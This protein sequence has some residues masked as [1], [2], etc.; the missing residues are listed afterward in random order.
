MVILENTRIHPALPSEGATDRPRPDYVMTEMQ[1]T[2]GWSLRPLGQIQY[3]LSS[4][5]IP[6]PFTTFWLVLGSPCNNFPQSHHHHGRKE[7]YD[8]TN[9]NSTVVT[10]IF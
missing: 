3:S 9:N 1:E 6:S 4:D 5:T 7:N 2:G 8:I 10:E